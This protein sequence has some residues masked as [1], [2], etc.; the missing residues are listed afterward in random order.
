MRLLQLSDL[1]L[2]ADPS[3]HLRG[4][5]T[6]DTLRRC[7]EAGLAEGPYDGILVSGDIVHDEPMGYRHL[8]DLLAGSNIPVMCLPGNHDNP[9]A[10]HAAFTDR[11]FSTLGDI[12]LGAGLL[13]GLDSTVPGEVGGFLAES[14]L[15]RLEWCLTHHPGVP[16]VVALHHPPVSLGSRWLDAIGL[17]EPERLFAITDR[18]AQVRAILFGHAHQAYAR[19]R[20]GVLLVCAPATSA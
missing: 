2:H 18:F 6:R 15:Q 3:G 9:A 8:R 12:Q 11:P 20:R 19:R 5:V 14:E 7:I 1:H 10:L 13:I 17:A 4:T 16:T